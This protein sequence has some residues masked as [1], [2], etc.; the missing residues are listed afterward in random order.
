MGILGQASDKPQFELTP[1]GEYV[2]TL[3]DLTLETGQWGDQIKWVWL[4]SPINDP[5]N[6]VKRGSEDRERELWQFTK[7]GLPKGSRAREWAEALMGRELRL[8][9]DPDDSDLLRHRMIA[10]LT[11]KPKKS[12]PT[13]K[14]ETI[15]EGSARPFRAAQPQRSAPKP[16]AS[17]ADV[18]AQLAE[19]DALR[20][21]F[22]KLVRNAELE[23]L[24]G[25]ETWSALNVEDMA[26][27]D[28][29][30]FEADIRS[31]MRQAAA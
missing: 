23:E 27:E 9:E 6:Y 31:A 10:Y 21:R 8:G 11:H 15:S 20:K 25:W 18:D 12:D 1:I 19:S 3:W 17:Q 29:R 30:S 13:V 2:F 7:V 28:I 14:Q 5:D 16:V 24:D 4:I 22:K 26:D